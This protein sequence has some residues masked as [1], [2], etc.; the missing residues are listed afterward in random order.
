MQPGLSHNKEWSGV[1]LSDKPLD[2][3][4]G[5]RGDVLLKVKLDLTEEQLDDYEWIEEGKA[6]REWLIPA[7]LVNAKGTVRIAGEEAT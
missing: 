4:E 2:A 6:Y 1:W 3:N 7:A 5:A